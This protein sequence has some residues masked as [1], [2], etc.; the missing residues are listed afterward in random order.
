MV[1]GSFPYPSSD[2]RTV[3]KCIQCGQL[4]F[5]QS[6]D[7]DIEALI[8]CLTNLNPNERPCIHDILDDPIF[9]CIDRKP[10]KSSRPAS[11]LEPTEI[12]GELDAE[13]W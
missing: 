11:L 12:E 10:L 6:M 5:P 3:F 7:R 4:L 13:V 1:T 8:R 2:Q 9:D